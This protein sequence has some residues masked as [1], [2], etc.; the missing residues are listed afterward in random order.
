MKKRRR[1]VKLK[2]AAAKLKEQCN[3]EKEAKKLLG[4]NVMLA[5]SLLARIN[6]LEAA[7]TLQDIIVQPQYHFHKL[8]NKKRR[9]LEGYFAMDVKTRKEQWRI[10]LQPLDE[11]EQPFEKYDI[12]KIAKIVKIVEITEVSKHYE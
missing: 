5:I 4:G 1:G 11:N 7:E 8:E 10:I 3:K 6:A 2:Y 12:D 9:N